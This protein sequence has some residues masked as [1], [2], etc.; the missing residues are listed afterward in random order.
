MLI[1]NKRGTLQEPVE[2]LR[3]KGN[4]TQTIRMCH[5]QESKLHVNQHV[6][7]SGEKQTGFYHY[8]TLNLCF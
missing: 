7:L 4:K 3:G 2:N 6:G 8:A 5:P 1:L